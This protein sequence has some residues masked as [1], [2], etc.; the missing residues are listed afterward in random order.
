MKK[1]AVILALVFVMSLAL[2]ACNNSTPAESTPAESTPA[3]STPAESTPEESVAEPVD[4]S[5]E[6][7]VDESSEEPVDESSE[8]PEESSK[9]PVVVGDENVALGK[10][11][12]VTGSGKGLILTKE[13]SEYP[14]HYNADLTDGVTSPEISYAE[15][16]WFSVSPNPD[17]G[18]APGG[19]CGIVVD[20]GKDTAVNCARVHMINPGEA[21]IGAP[22]EIA[23]AVSSDGKTFKTVASQTSFEEGADAY[24]VDFGFDSTNARYVQFSF[25]VTAVHNFIDELAVIAG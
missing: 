2:A 19:V 3:E 16:V 10:S 13:Q 21:G 7:P 14:C 15:D 20:L 4:E 1:I 5:S 8:E 24:W 12:T 22:S 25:T 23:I 17:A 18:N 9:E 6:E 11:Y